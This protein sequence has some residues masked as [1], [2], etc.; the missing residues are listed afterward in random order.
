M[1]CVCSFR[2]RIGYS[3]SAGSAYSRLP[4]LWQKFTIYCTQPGPLGNHNSIAGLQSGWILDF[5]PANGITDKVSPTHQFELVLDICA[6]HFDGLNAQMK[7]LGNLARPLA[8]S[9]ELE[10]FEL[11]VREAF[12]RRMGDLRPVPGEDLQYLGGSLIARVYLPTQDL[13]D[14]P[15]QQLAALLLHDVAAPAS[16]SQVNS[17]ESAL[18]I[19]LMPSML[20]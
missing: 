16:P 12:H 13:A 5:R 2:R 1:M 11:A 17:T 9:D 4:R 15:H 10:D 6:V 3:E 7:V 18:A 14:S 20:L 8:L 19:A